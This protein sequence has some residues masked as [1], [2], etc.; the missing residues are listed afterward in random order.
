MIR[1]I[2]DVISENRTFY[3]YGA[4]TRGR[5]F[6][7]ALY[8]TGYLR[9]LAGFVVESISDNPKVIE[10]IEVY[11]IG[12]PHI[13]RKQPIYISIADPK[14][15]EE[16]VDKLKI[17]GFTK[18]IR[19]SGE[20][21]YFPQYMMA[22]K[23]FCDLDTS[24]QIEK[25]EYD[26]PGFLHII[27]QKDQERL[28]NCCQW[29]FFYSELKTL[30]TIKT[31]FFPKDRLLESFE[32]SY[33]CYLTLKE[34]LEG[35]EGRDTPRITHTNIYSAQ[36]VTD[37]AERLLP[38]P[39]YVV[40]I[41]VGAATTEERVCELTDNAGM[42]ISALNSDF[43]ECTA[44]YYM[45]KNIQD[46]DYV[47]LFHYARYIDITEVE[48]G[49]LDQAGVDIVVTTPMLVDAPIKDFFCPRYIPRQDW[50][51]MERFLIK[52][53]P[54]YERTL[55]EYNK[56]FCYPGANLSIMRKK[57]FDEYAEF[58]FT[59]MKEIVEYYRKEDVVREDRYAG[60][61]ME[62]LT[63]MFVMHNKENYKIAYTDFLYVKKI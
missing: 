30:V 57:I 36:H 28:D 24:I 9:R 59:V 63:A 25:K 12:D 18:I 8:R 6:Q 56:T 62:N 5:A 26:E 32:D 34:A 23:L 17:S 54:E 46:V 29:R 37:R 15:V 14:V 60:Y 22:K 1:E 47:G 55:Q 2:E 52:H 20:D 53:Y 10:G 44:L 58:A 35:T 11:E 41:Q 40:P 48:L 13:D 49:K 50:E 42:N 7:H 39:S 38:L 61:L 45:W 4:G 51:L 27:I 43:S 21:I 3:V 16:V 33:G 31:Q 19:P